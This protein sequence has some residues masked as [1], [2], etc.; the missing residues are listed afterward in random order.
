[1]DMFSLS[2][3]P[4]VAGSGAKI[5]ALLLNAPSAFYWNLWV[6]KKKKLILFQDKYRSVKIFFG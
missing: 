5:S 6:E 2:L 3:G 1:M 4:V